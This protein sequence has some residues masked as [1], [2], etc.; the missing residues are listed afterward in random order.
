MNYQNYEKWVRTLLHNF[1]PGNVV[2]IDNAPYHN[3]QLDKT[4]TSSS[5][6][7]DM[8][9]WLSRRNIPCTGDLLKSEAHQNA[10]TQV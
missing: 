2:V 5:R 10:Q 1:L 9:T 4:P 3:V 8:Q 6:K 7:A